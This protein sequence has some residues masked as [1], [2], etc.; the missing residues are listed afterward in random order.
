MTVTFEWDDEK[1]AANIEKHGVAFDEAVL[2][3]DDPARRIV[4]DPEHSDKEDRWYC[5][6]RVEEKIMTVRFTMREQSVRIIG[7]GYWRKW[8]KY[9]EQAH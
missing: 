7:A 6:G 8:R 2:A 3:F 5:V 4:F 1:N 9:Y